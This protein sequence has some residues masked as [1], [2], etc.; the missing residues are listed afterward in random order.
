MGGGVQGTGPNVCPSLSCP[1]PPPHP[2]P[3]LSR[4]DLETR[5]DAGYAS[6]ELPGD[7]ILSLP[8]L[9][10]EETSD[11]LISPYASFS[12]TADR[13]MP[14]LSG[15]LDKLSPQGWDCWEGKGSETGWWGGGQVLGAPP[16]F[17]FHLSLILAPPFFRNYV[18][19]RRF[20]QFNGRSLMYFGNDK[21]GSRRCC[22]GS[23][24]MGR[25]V[26]W[27]RLRIGKQSLHD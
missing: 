15:W 14:L 17:S 25:G 5:E 10:T 18:F 3:R 16:G 13:P 23:W 21:V 20:V 2:P 4:Q 8:T 27:R 9:N 6:L 24:E 7:S 1:P 12:S 22:M 11:D 26:G 19:Q